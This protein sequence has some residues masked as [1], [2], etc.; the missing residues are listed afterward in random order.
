[1]GR[2]VREMGKADDTQLAGIRDAVTDLLG[3]YEEFMGGDLVTYLCTWR[4]AAQQHQ[5]RRAAPAAAAVT[6]LVA[7]HRKRAS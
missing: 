2:V 3:R 5:E 4:E 6:S 1:M 7:E